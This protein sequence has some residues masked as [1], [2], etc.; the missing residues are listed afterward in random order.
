VR[1]VAKAD[2]KVRFTALLHHV[3]V[4]S[5]RRAFWALKRR[6]APG[7]DGVTWLAYKR[8]LEANLQ[9]LHDRLHRG[10]YRPKPSRRVFIPKAD[11]RQRPLGIATVEDKI[12]QSAVVAVLN[13]IYEA[14]FYG[15][16]YGFRPGRKPHDALDA[17]AVGLERKK[18]RWVLDADIKDFFTSLDHGR[19]MEFVEQRIGDK[20]V[21]RLTQKWLGAGVIEDGTWSESEQGTPQGAT[22]SPLLANV[23]LHYVFDQW[24][25]RWRNERASGEVLVVRYADDFVVGFERRADAVRF[26]TELGERLAEYG[27]ELKA[28]KTR[29]IEFGRYACLNR[30]ERGLGKPE[31]FDFLGFTHISGKDRSGR[32]QVKR[33]T[34]AKR[35]RAKLKEV[36]AELVRRMHLPTPKIGH[37]LESVVQGHFAYYA[38]PGNLDAIR[39]FRR[40]VG[41]HWRR[42]LKRR[43]QRDRVTWERMKRLFDRWLPKPVVLHPYPNKRFDARPQGRSPVR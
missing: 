15:F 20:R 36:K 42:A 16:S 26:R 22:V 29:L 6:A 1:E 34:I 37:W 2:R 24:V 3:D 11:G 5:L 41:R 35:M 14:D 9:D 19:L 40:Q 4:E 30:A 17:L 18:V 33:I 21:L 28:E 7:V 25:E 39:G 43:S 8:E 27:L 10:A 38:V 13:A 23:Y 32:F 31:T 12:V